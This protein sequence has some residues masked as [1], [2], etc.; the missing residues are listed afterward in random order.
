MHSP[1]RFLPSVF[2][3]RRP[4]H[5]TFFVTRRCNARC[6]F[7]FYLERDGKGANDKEI[8][9]D[10]AKRFS[11]SL[12]KL[13][14]LAFSGGEI[15]LRE[16]LP[17]LSRVLYEA[18]SPSIM[19]YPTNGLMPRLI[20]EKTEQILKDCREARVVV[21]LSLDGVGSEHDELRG[22][23]GSFDKV[24]ETYES[25]RGLLYE[26]RN[27][28]LGINTV[29]C[30]INQDRMHGIISFVNGLED[31]RTHTISMARGDIMD[32]SYKEVDTGKY[33]NAIRTLEAGL[34]DGS[35]ATYGFRGAGVKAAQDILQRRIIH[36]TLKEN[37][38]RI[39]CYAGRL[40]LVM[41]ETGDVF[42]CEA[43]NDEM[44]LGNIRDCGYDVGE[45]LK[46][47][48]TRKVVSRIRDACFC[49]HECYLMTNI[50]FNPR[51]WPRLLWEYVQ[52]WG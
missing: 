33:L 25:L 36:R 4:L 52:L 11:P 23:A 24:L 46:D 3:K 49:T 26:Y 44:K 32:G 40:N 34:K 8:S 14:W 31:V 17:E 47:G 10:E 15:Y 2:S 50:L 41:T 37:R 19:L 13:L 39:P 12:G 28:E 42:P 1:L 30:S 7:C 22:V 20:K 51:T 45:L 18:N 43:F 48:R 6:P 27:F 21:K 29:F 16:D 35:C 5:F 9:L 38:R